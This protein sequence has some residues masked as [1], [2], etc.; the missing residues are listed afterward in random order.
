MKQV[1]SNQVNLFFLGDRLVL[2]VAI[3]LWAPESRTSYTNGVVFPE[4]CQKF[5][6]RPLSFGTS[7]IPTTHSRTDPVPRS[8]SPI[9]CPWH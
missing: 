5:T 3:L 7:A 8:L 4:D 1:S 6:G 9:W 2:L